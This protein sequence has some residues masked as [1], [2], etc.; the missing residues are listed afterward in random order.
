MRTSGATGHRTLRRSP[1]LMLIAAMA[2]AAAIATAAVARA[3]A[4]NWAAATQQAKLTGADGAT[5]DRFGVAVAVDGDTVLV[6][7]FT[8]TVGINSNQGSAF[9]FVR[10]GGTWSQQ[11]KLTAFAG[12]A[13]DFFGYG[14]ALSGDTAVIGAYGENSNRGSAYVFVRSGGVWSQQ[15]RLTAFDGI[16]GDY[17]GVSA[18]VSGDTAV[19]C[20]FRKHGQQR[21]YGRHHRPAH[22]WQPGKGAP[23]PVPPQLRGPGRRHPLRRRRLPAVVFL[24]KRRD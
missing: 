4:G 18:A 10:S 2:A 17:F 5:N 7:A 12:A 20:H 8:D 15:A 11:A 21:C 24:V 6:G 22:W 3:M 9:V 1:L 23:V 13:N 19:V 14:V 16:A